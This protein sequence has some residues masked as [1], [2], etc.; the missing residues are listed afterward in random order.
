M[1]KTFFF[2]QKEIKQILI[3]Y[4]RGRNPE[5]LSNSQRIFY[6]DYHYNFTSK[7]RFILYVKQNKHLNK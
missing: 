5:K 2:K 3:T 7:I 6:E 1:W 4:M